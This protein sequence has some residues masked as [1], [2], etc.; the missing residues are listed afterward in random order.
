[1]RAASQ[2]ILKQE[3]T[4]DDAITILKWMKNKEITRYLNETFNITFELQQTID[5]VNMLIMTHLFNREG[6]FYLIY[7]Y[8]N[9]PVGFLK[10]VR[11]HKE[12]EII[13]V[14]GEMRC[15]GRA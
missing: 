11:K 2:I 10:L 12:T 13:I 1:M 8:N 5:R 7:P 3:V 4:R 6:S 15:W 9:E 14:I